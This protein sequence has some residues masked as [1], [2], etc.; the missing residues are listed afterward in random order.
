MG[1]VIKNR[2]EVSFFIEKFKSDSI[3]T[4]IDTHVCGDSTH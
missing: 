2:L 3:L 1:R 4:N